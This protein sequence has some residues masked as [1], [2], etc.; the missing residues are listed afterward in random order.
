MSETVNDNDLKQR[1][2]MFGL[3]GGMGAGKST[4]GRKFSEL[5]AEVIDADDVVRGLNQPGQAG[6]LAMVEIIG[7]EVV[8]DEGKLDAEKASSIIFAQ[9][10]LKR[11]VEQAIHP[12]VWGTMNS[13]VEDLDPKSIAVLEVPLLTPETAKVF[14][15]VVVVNTARERAIG[16][17]I[18]NRGFTREKAEARINTQISN[19]NRAAMADYI[20]ENNG[21]FDEFMVAIHWAWDWMQQ[22]AT[23]PNRTD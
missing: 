1:A 9:P 22:V 6:F 12:L 2:A 11:E 16:Q 10:A 13:Q 20:I 18:A 8:D 7:E 14:D 5:G 19:K 21:T 4:A 3:T 17:L 15:G 23:E